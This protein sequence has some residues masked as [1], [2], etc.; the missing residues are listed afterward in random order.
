[1]TRSGVP[2]RKLLSRLGWHHL[3]VSCHDGQGR[4][5]TLQVRRHSTARIEVEL[6][7]GQRARLTNEEAGHLRAALREVLVDERRSH[8]ADVT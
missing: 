6:P 5:S 3:T 8:R 7:S 1:M 4:R 2:A